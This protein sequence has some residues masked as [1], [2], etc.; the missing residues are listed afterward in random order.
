MMQ[1]SGLIV[2]AILQKVGQAF[3]R[4]KELMLHQTDYGEGEQQTL[5]V[6]EKDLVGFDPPRIT[7]GWSFHVGGDG[8]NSCKGSNVYALQEAH[9]PSLDG[10]QAAPQR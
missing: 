6:D 4:L 10:F 5:M 3:R 1:P 7:T 9:P 2:T 8:A